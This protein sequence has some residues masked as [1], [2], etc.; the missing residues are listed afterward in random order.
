MQIILDQTEKLEVIHNC[1]TT[2]MTY[3]PDYGFSLDYNREDYKKA[4]A[5][6]IESGK[7]ADEI[8]LEDVQTEMLRMG[9]GLTFTDEE[10]DGEETK[11][12]TLEL[13]EQNWGKIPDKRVIEMVLGDWDAETADVVVQCILFGE[14]TFG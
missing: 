1:L 3:F 8:C 14:I 7:P 10:N 9:F 13:I 12:L 11:T 6:L 2:G 4:K 5:S